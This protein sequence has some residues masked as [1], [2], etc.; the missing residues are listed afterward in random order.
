MSPIKKDNKLQLKQRNIEHRCNLYQEQLKE[1]LVHCTIHNKNF[2]HS[3][4]S[5]NLLGC[6]SC[7]L[8]ES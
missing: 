6:D 3:T 7:S 8:K 5:L 1:I 2:E 4:N